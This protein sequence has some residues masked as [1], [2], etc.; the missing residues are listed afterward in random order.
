VYSVEQ[1]LLNYNKYY[2]YYLLTKKP[3]G[4]IFKICISTQYNRVLINLKREKGKM[5]FERLS[6]R[7]KLILRAIIDD[8]IH[9]AEPV[10]SRSISKRHE[11][12]LSSATIRN[13][14]ADLEE[15]GYL[16]QPHTSAGR[17]PSDKGYRFY[18]DQLMEP[19]IPSTEEME[20][21]RNA[22]EGTISELSQFIRNASNVVSKVT[23]YT[24]LASAPLSKKKSLKTVQVVYIDSGKALVVGIT[25]TGMVKNVLVKVSNIL[26]PDMLLR[27]SNFLNEHLSGRTLDRI[28]FDLLKKSGDAIGLDYNLITPIIKGVTDCINLA[29]DSEV[30]FDGATNIFNYPEF[31]DTVRAK[32]FLSMLDEKEVIQKILFSDDSNRPINIKIGRE[33]EF[34]E[35]KDCTVVLTSYRIGNSIKGTFGIIGPTRM[36]YSKVISSIHY[37]RKKLDQEI[38]KLIGDIVD[39]E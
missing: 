34:E 16:E 25:N 3:Y 37:I 26:T 33:N 31:S 29:D 22:L 13:E 7:K 5:P 9:S 21:I 28:D 15:M 39:E 30:F 24:S 4:G 14:M 35:V 19:R 23:R 27:V 17:V 36:E 12:S 18:V 38:R 10:G 2:P 32:E 6:E 1:R 20:S 11:L 8:Y